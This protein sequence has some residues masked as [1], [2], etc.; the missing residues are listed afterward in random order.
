[1]NRFQLHHLTGR[2]KLAFGLAAMV[3]LSILATGLVPSLWAQVTGYSK[4]MTVFQAPG[5]IGAAAV[6]EAPGFQ[7]LNPTY[8]PQGQW[9]FSLGGREEG[10]IN[11]LVLTYTDGG[12]F[13]RVSESKAGQGKTLPKGESRK[14]DDE[15]AVL[16]SGLAG[17][18]Q[19]T[20]ITFE[21]GKQI[22]WYIA[23]ARIDLLSNL[24]EQEMLS[25]AESL[26]P[27]QKRD[28]RFLPRAEGPD[29]AYP[30]NPPRAP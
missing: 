14:V 15:P 24:P 13:I 3:L 21:D 9:Q 12:R 27:A 7:P 17:T 30:L 10:G 2:K 1:M 11:Y 25:V 26:K 6:S 4:P 23:D 8:L 18:I 16:V 22:T 20:S 19:F 5:G 29:A 28:V